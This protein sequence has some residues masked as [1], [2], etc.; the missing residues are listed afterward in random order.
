MLKI[1]SISAA[2]RWQNSK[3]AIS[4]D[5][6]NSLDLILPRDSGI[7]YTT[8]K[9]ELVLSTAKILFFHDTSCDFYYKTMSFTASL[10]MS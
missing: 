4:V 8:N 9:Q 1:N 10:G 7:Y 3:K 6:R 5:F 2:I